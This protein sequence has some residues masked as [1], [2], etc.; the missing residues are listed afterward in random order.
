MSEFFFKLKSQNLFCGW[1][2]EE[3]LE[4]V[5]K[6]YFTDRTRIMNH[7]FLFF[8]KNTFFEWSNQLIWSADWLIRSWSDQ[9]DQQ[10]RLISSSSDQLIIFFLLKYCQLIFET[11]TWLA[12]AKVL[13]SDL[14]D[15][16][17]RSIVKWS[18]RQILDFSE[19][20]YCP[21]IFQI[22][23]WLSINTWLSTNTLFATDSL[24]VRYFICDRFFIGDILYW[25]SRSIE[26]L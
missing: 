19:P 13:S 25:R 11:N 10:I 1:S 7:T 3:W 4:V 2:G 16:W 24:L 21:L 17:C 20:K 9:A 8:E 22:K 5:S 12:R 26:R 23:T 14:S 6:K 15:M 18:F